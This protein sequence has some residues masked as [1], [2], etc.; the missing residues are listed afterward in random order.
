MVPHN[1]NIADCSIKEIVDCLTTQ[2]YGESAGQLID[3]FE[4]MPNTPGFDWLRVSCVP[5]LFHAFEKMVN[6]EDEP[7]S[8]F[9]KTL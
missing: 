1:K 5:Y 4:K 6:S 3:I 8:F 7:V 9:I 2:P